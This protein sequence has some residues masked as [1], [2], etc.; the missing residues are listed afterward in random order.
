MIQ[1]GE[2]NDQGELLLIDKWAEEANRRVRAWLCAYGQVRLEFTDDGNPPNV[3]MALTLTD[4]RAADLR[5]ALGTSAAP[6][7]AGPPPP[8]A[9]DEPARPG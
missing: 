9:P 4:Y 1:R 5:D 6:P 8:A 7:A 2:R 3:L